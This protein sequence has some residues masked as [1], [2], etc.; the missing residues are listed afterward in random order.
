MLRLHWLY[1][2]NCDE[3]VRSY[4]HWMK[5][6]NTLRKIRGG[7]ETFK[8]RCSPGRGWGVSEGWIIVTNDSVRHAARRI[9]KIALPN[10]LL[11]G[12]Q[13]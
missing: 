11:A 8:V 12:Q 3:G 9:S 10:Y 2:R 13:L 1:W 5:M 6:A 7:A 4:I